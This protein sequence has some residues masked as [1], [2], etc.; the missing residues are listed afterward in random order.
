[1]ESKP[2][3]NRLLVNYMRKNLS[4]KV[5][6]HF[7]RGHIKI[8]ASDMLELLVVGADPML[9]YMSAG[10]ESFGEFMAIYSYKADYRD[11]KY[12][13]DNICKDGKSYT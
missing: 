8:S 5:I 11:L 2:N 1:M 4:H 10:K 7:K 9:H 12:R 13:I 6:L 3:L